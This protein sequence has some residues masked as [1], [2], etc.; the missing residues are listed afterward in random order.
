MAGENFSATGWFLAF[1]VY[2][3][4]MFSGVILIS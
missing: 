1:V 3:S 2:G 4:I